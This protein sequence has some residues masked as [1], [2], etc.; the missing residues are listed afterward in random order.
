MTLLYG[1]LNGLTSALTSG[2]GSAGSQGG[3]GSWARYS[4]P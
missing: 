1:Q 2:T 3:S 4:L